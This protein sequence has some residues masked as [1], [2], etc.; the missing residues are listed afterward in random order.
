MRAIYII[1]VWN[2]DPSLLVKQNMLSL[3][4]IQLEF[5]TDHLTLIMLLF[6]L[7]CTAETILDLAE[8]RP[9]F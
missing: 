2:L 6:I 1:S 5:H 9:A 8:R 4:K 7:Y 3:G